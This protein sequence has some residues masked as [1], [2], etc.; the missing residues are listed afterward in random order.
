MSFFLLFLGH[1][2]S[3]IYRKMLPPISESSSF[4]I[5][6][7]YTKDYLDTLEGHFYNEGPFLKDTI[8]KD[9]YTEGHLL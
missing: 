9:I 8:T 4:V 2:L 6:D 7:I 5:L 1:S 3:N